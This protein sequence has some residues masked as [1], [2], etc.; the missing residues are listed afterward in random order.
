M[1]SS[2]PLDN[3]ENARFAWDRYK[4]LMRAMFAFTVLTV[5]AVLGY[6]YLENGMVS[7]HF[8]IAVALGIGAMMMLTAAL[9]GLAFLSNGTG[10]DASIEDRLGE[11]VED[12]WS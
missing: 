6:L 5:V 7:I 3:P 11:E 9:M 8:Y 10:H 1:V 12:F 4:R 2:S